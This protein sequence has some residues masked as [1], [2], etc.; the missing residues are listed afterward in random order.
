M[1]I[2][3]LA[4]GL[5]L[6][7]FVFGLTY[8]LIDAAISLDHSRSQNQSL[9]K[10]CQQLSKIANESLRGKSVSELVG[11]NASTS[12]VKHDGTQLRINSVVLKI[13]NEKVVEVNIAETC[14]QE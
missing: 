11:K 8:M 1:K 14:G 3:I 6:L 12:I 9:Q 4:T 13:A 7:L 2:L 5:A 10:I